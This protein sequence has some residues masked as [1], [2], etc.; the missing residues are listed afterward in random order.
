MKLYTEHYSE[1]YRESG[2]PVVFS[3]REWIV[4]DFHRVIM[5]DIKLLVRKGFDVRVIHNIGSSIWNNKFINQNIAHDGITVSRVPHQAENFY[6]EV[7]KIISEIQWWVEKLILL[8]RN[9]LLNPDGSRL[10]TVSVNSITD[11][12]E[13]EYNFWKISKRNINFQWTLSTL[14]D[15]ISKDVIH[16]AHILDAWKKS[17][18]RN[19][20][21]SIEWSGTLLGKDFGNPDVSNAELNEIES[22]FGILK[23]DKSWLIKPRSK[24]YIFENIQNFL[25]ARIDGIPVWCVERKVIDNESIELWALCVIESF[26][27][28]KIGKT[29]IGDFHQQAEQQNMKIVCFT[30]NERLKW[31]LMSL[32]YRVENTLYKERRKISPWV[33]MYFK[34]NI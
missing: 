11:K 4:R 8:E 23:W 18:I 3:A 16:R 1:V 13:K 30:N 17:S 28:Q 7:L 12:E 10:N 27:S 20:L 19:E 21:F 34:D 6:E 15:A 33:T 9:T 32:W 24:E 25:I 22:V 2:K 29:L 14:C 5:P 26:L 31:F